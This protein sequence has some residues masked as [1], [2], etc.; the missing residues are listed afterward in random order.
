MDDDF[1]GDQFEPRASKLMLNPSWYTT[2]FDVEYELN[3]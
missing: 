2:A 1:A 3:E